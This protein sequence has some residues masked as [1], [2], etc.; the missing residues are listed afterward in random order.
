MLRPVICAGLNDV[1]LQRLGQ[2]LSTGYLVC[3]F[4]PARIAF[5][6]LAA[7][8]LRG[9]PCL[10]VDVLLDTFKQSLTPVDLNVLNDAV[11]CK[12]VYQPSLRTKLIDLFSQCECLEVP[13][14]D[15]L[16]RLCQRSASYLFVEKPLAAIAEIWKGVPVEHQQ[17]WS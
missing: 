3:G 16:L 6:T 13:K 12:S 15:D 7:I 2:I 4:F 14:P 8:L 9:T 11:A 5:P 10:P 17:F 1:A